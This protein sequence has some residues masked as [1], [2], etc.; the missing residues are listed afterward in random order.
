MSDLRMV[1]YNQKFF[2][3]KANLF[4]IEDEIGSPSIL[5]PGATMQIAETSILLSDSVKGHSCTGGSSGLRSG[6]SHAAHSHIMPP[7]PPEQV[8]H[9]DLRVAL[10]KEITWAVS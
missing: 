5:Q 2:P 7:K 10:F 6:Q 1:L 8:L 9:F 3:R 4:A